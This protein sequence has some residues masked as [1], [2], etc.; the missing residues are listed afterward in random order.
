MIVKT[1]R[2]LI[3][4]KRQSG[5]TYEQMSTDLSIT[6]STVQVV[7][8]RK[9]KKIKKTQGPK[10]I[11]SK[12]KELVIKRLIFKLN[13]KKSIVGNYWKIQTF[14]YLHQRYIDTNCVIIM[15]I[16]SQ[17]SVYNY[18]TY[19]KKRGSTVPEPGFQKI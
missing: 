14:Q 10:R 13:E 9:L 19:I 12:S 6:K 18:R 3:L 17:T 11:I 16:E 4:K 2:E 15:N 7:V 1:I 8:N 5:L